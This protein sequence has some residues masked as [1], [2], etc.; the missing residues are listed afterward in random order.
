[1]PHHSVIVYRRGGQQG[2]VLLLGGGGFL[3]MHVVRALLADG[4]RPLPAGRRSGSGQPLEDADVLE[5]HTRDPDWWRARVSAAL[6]GGEHVAGIVNLVT[7]KAGDRAAIE[8]VNVRAVEAM[9]AARRGLARPEGPPL[10]LHIGSVSEYRESAHVSGYAAGKRAARTACRRSGAVD[11][12]LTLGVVTGRVRHTATSRKLRRVLRAL[13]L[14][15]SS[16]T[17]GV[18]PA[19]EVG[20]AIAV[21]IR[22]GR[23]I[24]EAAQQLPVELV[25][26]GRP[27]S[28]GRYLD[29]PDRGGNGRSPA[30]LRPALALE[31]Y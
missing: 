13:P 7:R 16:V 26:S 23:P 30:W 12:V 9:A 22:H 8:V 24:A 28:W 5:P 2:A 6:G 31:R 17:V 1:M 4:Q 27:L 20:E 15:R 14:L 11:L 19:T 18:S 21:L 29:L 10:T 25:L 3:G